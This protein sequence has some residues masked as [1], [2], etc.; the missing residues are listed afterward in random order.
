MKKLSTLIV[1]ALYQVAF[2]QC[3]I[4][5]KTSIEK[6][7]SEAYWVDVEA[8]CEE[9]YLWTTDSNVTIDGSSKRKGIRIKGTK[10]GVTNLSAKVMTTN[11]IATCKTSIN[12]AGPAT[13]NPNI[14]TQN[15]GDSSSTSYNSGNNCEI[16][17]NKFTEAKVFDDNNVVFIPQKS[18]KEYKYDWTVTYA[19]GKTASSTDRISLFPI[20]NGDSPINE[21]KMRIIE[22]TCLR[23]LSRNYGMEFWKPVAS[24]A[25]IEQKSY[26]Q[27][28]YKD[29]V[30]GQDSK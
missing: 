29:Y 25:K 27:T 28:S 4:L 13:Q 18:E 20:K 19:N 10:E 17:V 14:V 1:L 3:T 22:G 5:G 15:S 9:C 6:G 8:Q 11:G 26:E 12:V 30:G 2:S 23:V 16:S 24:P 7:Q 21:V